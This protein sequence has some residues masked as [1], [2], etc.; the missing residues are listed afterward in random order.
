MN[1][2]HTASLNDL[3]HHLAAYNKRIRTFLNGEAL[4]RQ[5]YEALNQNLVINN[6]MVDKAELTALFNQ[7]AGA[8]NSDSASS[9]M[10]TLQTIYQSIN[11]QMSVAMR[12]KDESVECDLE[13]FRC[14]CSVGW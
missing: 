14:S 3:I 11:S 5:S 10:R 8:R 13:T 6:K 12:V 4:S 9:S 1:E 2:E 7:I